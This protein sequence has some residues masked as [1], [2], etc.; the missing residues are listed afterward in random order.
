ME[1]HYKLPIEKKTDKTVQELMDEYR[2]AKGVWLLARMIEPEEKIKDLEEK[3]E[4]LRHKIVRK[5][6]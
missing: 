1:K 5:L 2:Q 3:I 6:N 4:T